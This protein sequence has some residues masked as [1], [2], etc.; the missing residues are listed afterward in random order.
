MNIRPNIKTGISVCPHDCPS[1]CALEV[2]LLDEHTIGRVRGAKD[3]SY[4]L[5]VICEKVSR[6]AERI[7][8]PDRLLYPLKRVGTKGTGQFKRI[9]W[10]EAMEE[11]A[12]AFLKAEADYGSESVW[13]YYYAGTMGLV[14]RDGIERLRHT[15]KY[16]GMYGTFCIALS[17][18]GYFAG[19]GKI[20]G[21]DP[22]EMQKSDLIV[23]W[24]GNPV[25][26]QVNVMTHAMKARKDRGAKIACVDIYDTGTMKQADIKLLIRPGTDG[27]LACAI[28]HVLFR[29][30]YAD[31]PYLEDLTD[32]PSEFEAHLKTKTPEWASKICDIPVAEI[33]VFAK[34][35]GETKRAYFRLGY[36]FSRSRNGAVNMHAVS[37]IPAVTGAWKY[38]GGG[39]LHSN[40]GIYKW[41][42]KLIEGTDAATG[43]LRVIDQSRIGPA[44]LGDSF[45]L[46]GGPPV[47]A[48]LIQNTN[49]ASVAPDQTKVK[50]GLAREDLF[51]CVHEQFM[52]ETAKF[53]DIVLPATMFLEHDDVYQG[54]GHQHIMFGRKLVEAPGECRSNH[55]VLCDLAGRVGAKHEG[56]TKT[57]RELIDWTLQH[58]HR[59]DLRKLDTENWIDVQPDFETSHNLKRFGHADG[60]FHFKP[61]W[62]KAAH[63]SPTGP[64]GPLQDM[65]EFP[66]HWEAIE[67]ATVEYPFRL[68]TSPA[69]AFLNSTFNETPSSRKREGRPTLFVHPLDLQAAGL[70]DG[71][72]VTVG[73]ARGTVTLHAK[74]HDGQRRGVLIAESIWPNEAFEDGQGINTLT[75]CDQPAPA[76]GGTYHDNR[77]WLRPAR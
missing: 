77:V 60:K 24:G 28:M 73:S 57:P 5:G 39:A 49:P 13:P 76:S 66:D 61:D 47:K 4:T 64:L 34:L 30:G 40:S 35:I 53:A 50:Q 9:S 59:P 65:P 23:I 71:D 44:L 21:V 31:R 63:F 17:W 46:A 54:G 20:A 29:D 12:G 14:M 18:P 36:G 41:N 42:K 16:S 11:T 15:K 48:M 6:Y 25:N 56:F 72:K 33:E 38:E 7:H 75:G 52:T 19:V 32:C 10:D 69:R 74:A 62:T 27:A 37:C 70:A 51:V 22:R 1:A 58:S 68:A 2:E 67:E 3:N 55:E 8:H 26:T 43:G 45:D